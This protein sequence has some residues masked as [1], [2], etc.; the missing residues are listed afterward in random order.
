M[1][2]LHPQTRATTAV[3][4]ALGVMLCALG[5]AGCPGTVDPSLWPMATGSGGGGGSGAQACDPTPIFTM[6]ACAAGGCHNAT[7]AAASFDMATTGWQTHLVGVDPPGGGA[8]PSLCAG[9]GPY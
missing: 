6:K 8:N 1:E 4:C 2:G 5:A 7:A 3:R 9:H